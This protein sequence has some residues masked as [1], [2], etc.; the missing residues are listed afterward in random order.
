MLNQEISAHWQ[1]NVLA[2]RLI[3]TL[4]LPISISVCISACNAAP[5][6]T[7]PVDKHLSAIVDST[8]TSIGVSGA[9]LSVTQHGKLIHQSSHGFAQKYAYGGAELPA[10]VQMDATQIFDLASL[11]K[12]FATTFGVMLL[13]DDGRVELDASVSRYLPAFSGPH[14][15]SVTVRHLLTHSS[16]LH[17]WK[18]VYYHAGNA[19][20]SFDFI[21][22]LPLAAPVGIS[23]RYS[24]LGFMIL[25]YLIES[26]SEQSLDAFLQE[27]LYLPLGLERT[28][29]NP[30]GVDPSAFAATSHGNPFEKRM[31]ADDNFGYVCDEDPDA[32]T[33]WRTRVL[34]GEVNDGNAFHAHNGLAGHA[35]LF[36]TADELHMLINLLLNEGQYKGHQLIS[37]KTINTFLSKEDLGNGLGWAMSPAALMAEN[38]P[39]GSFGHTGFT[40]TYALAI[41]KHGLSILLLT[42]RQHAGVDSGG[43]YPSLNTF[44]SDVVQAI[45][46][47]IDD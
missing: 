8:I 15:D 43:R 42:N 41:P 12:V 47:K 33:K 45:L 24:D 2:N 10:P 4:L 35:G 19:Q 36:S 17:P 39:E 11:T 40:G 5:E 29:F 21:A 27:N 13:V 34:I 28:G 46:A 18:P 38:L 16:G 9:V 26:V 3:I 31:V 22:T 6:S 23:R 7:P 20:A 32:F 1:I 14:K 25:G 37:P 30:E 44:R